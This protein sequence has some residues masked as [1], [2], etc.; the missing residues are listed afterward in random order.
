LPS[1]RHLS[2]CQLMHGRIAHVSCCCA[3]RHDRCAWG[4]VLRARRVGCL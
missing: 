3:T 4:L 2:S 1:R